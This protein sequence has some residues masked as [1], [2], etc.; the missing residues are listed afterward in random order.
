MLPIDN[1]ECGLLVAGTKMDMSKFYPRQ[2]LV[3]EGFSR[4]D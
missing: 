1:G 4:F 2:T 3:K